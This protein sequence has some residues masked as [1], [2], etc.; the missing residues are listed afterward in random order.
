[1]IVR[2]TLNEVVIR[3]MSGKSYA[4][5]AAKLGQALQ[6]VSTDYMCQKGLYHAYVDDLQWLGHRAP[7][8]THGSHDKGYSSEPLTICLPFRVVFE[9][10]ACI[11][12]HY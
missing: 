5:E 9:E 1:M 10:I 8:N 4:F 7:A 6:T 11:S 12:S 2:E 3:V